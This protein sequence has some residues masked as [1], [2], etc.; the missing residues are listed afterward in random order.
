M[1]ISEVGINAVTATEVLC[2]WKPPS[3]KE[4]VVPTHISKLEVCQSKF[5]QFKPSATNQQLDFLKSLCADSRLLTLTYPIRFN[6]DIVTCDIEVDSTHGVETNAAIT[7]PTISAC[8][9]IFWKGGLS[10]K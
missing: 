8:F 3:F 2:K 6:I 7:I 5:T 9:F 4:S 10:F 1:R